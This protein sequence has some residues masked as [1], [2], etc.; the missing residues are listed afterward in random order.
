[1]KLKEV[2][3]D[4]DHLFMVFEFMEENLYELTKRRKDKPF[5]EV[6]IRN[7][8]FQML[9]GLGY[10]HKHGTCVWPRRCSCQSCG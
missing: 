8:V 2:I 9:Q 7:M 10:M 6:D 4:N 5:P 1:M 3:R